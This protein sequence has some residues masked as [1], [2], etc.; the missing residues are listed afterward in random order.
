MVVNVPS[1]DELFLKFREGGLPLF[2]CC[3]SLGL[4]ILVFSVI[5]SSSTRVL[6]SISAFSSSIRRDSC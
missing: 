4:L 5:S 3:Y 1:I 6:S 2:L